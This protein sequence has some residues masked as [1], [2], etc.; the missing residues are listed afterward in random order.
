[1]P[2]GAEDALNGPRSPWCPWCG[3]EPAHL[4]MEPAFCPNPQ[5]GLVCWNPRATAEEL[6]RT[7]TRMLDWLEE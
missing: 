4:G 1:M 3:S 6:S 5:C 2:A 7:E